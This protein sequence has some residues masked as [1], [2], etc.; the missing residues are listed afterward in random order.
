MLTYLPW[1]H[2]A[3]PPPSCVYFLHG[4][5][6]SNESFSCSG[7]EITHSVLSELFESPPVR[8]NR[9]SHWRALERSLT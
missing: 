9:L 7:P 1:N 2:I 4:K 8:T 3:R 5:A 6:M